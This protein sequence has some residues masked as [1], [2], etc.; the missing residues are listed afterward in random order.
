MSE[1][2]K[3]SWAEFFRLAHLSA[4]VIFNAILEQP[5]AR[6]FQSG[7]SINTYVIEL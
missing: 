2:P 4:P 6:R 7:A 1:C 5:A 3:K